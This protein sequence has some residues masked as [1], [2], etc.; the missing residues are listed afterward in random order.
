MNA[1]LF[2]KIHPFGALDHFLVV[3]FV[4]NPLDTIVHG[5]PLAINEYGT[6]LCDL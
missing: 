5:M 2:C 4:I 3:D 6:R 1:R